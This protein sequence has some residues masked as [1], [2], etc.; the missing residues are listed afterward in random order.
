LLSGQY[1]PELPDSIGAKITIV[2]IMF[3]SMS[4]FAIF[5]GTVSTIMVERLKEGAIM[6]RINF[7]DLENHIVICGWNDNVPRIIS[8]FQRDPDYK[9][10]SF[11][12][13]AE[14]EEL[15]DM[16]KYSIDMT[17][18]Y[19]VKRD[20]ISAETLKF[21]NIEGASSAIIFADQSKGRTSHDTD[22]RT[23]LAALT[24][25]KLNPL[26][27]TCAELIHSENESHLAMSH[28]ESIVLSSKIAAHMMAQA[29]KKPSVI[30]FYNHLID[31]SSENSIHESKFPSSQ[32]GKTFD[33]SII[34]WKKEFKAIL[35]GIINSKGTVLVNPEDYTITA[36]D[37]ALV[38]A[39]KKPKI[40]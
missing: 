18:I 11:I 25:E 12:I 7:H 3:C 35:V 19:L 6:G 34:M 22:A 28:V 36:E 21:V 20:F 23:V 31:P 30:P 5:T 32:I 33:E 10:K 2:L 27:Y 13:V 17:A 16:G 26:I 40:S 38:I 37:K 15:P 8:G 29:A 4:L 14:I 9:N 39:S 1:A 24:I